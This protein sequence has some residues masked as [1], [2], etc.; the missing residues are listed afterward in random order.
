M[1]NNPRIAGIS[2]LLKRW[3]AEQKTRTCE[4]MFT[5]FMHSVLTRAESKKFFDYYADEPCLEF[6]SAR[7]CRIK[8]HQDHFNVE[9]VAEVAESIGLSNKIDP[10]HNKPIVKNSPVE[11]RYE[12]HKI[13]NIEIKPRDLGEI[14]DQVAFIIQELDSL[15]YVLHVNGPKF[16]IEKDLYPIV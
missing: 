2:S 5:E 1:A 3:C 13:E 8:V 14:L 6:Y 10:R 11:E 7:M 9:A 12:V 16:S 4:H 15:G